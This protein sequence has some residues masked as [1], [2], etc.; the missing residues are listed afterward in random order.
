V[1]PARLGAIPMKLA[2]QALMN[3]A[4]HHLEKGSIDISM[5]FVWNFSRTLD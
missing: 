1:P 5:P 4:V 3:G 2:L